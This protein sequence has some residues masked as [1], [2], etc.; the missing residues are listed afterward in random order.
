M[1]EPD[2]RYRVVLSPLASSDIRA[3]LI[4]SRE[5]FGERAAAR[6]RDLLKQALR[7]IAA[8]PERPGSRE[9][10]DL[11]GGIRTYHVAY[12]RDHARA[13]L[14]VVKKP[15]HVLVYRR[16]GDDAINVVRVLHDARDL[17]RHLP[18]E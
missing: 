2:E 17:E 8:D 14:R 16:R 6:Y 5:R 15:R 11:A 3:A 7:D 12:S 9:R 18:E 1:P 10:P 4:W 13:G